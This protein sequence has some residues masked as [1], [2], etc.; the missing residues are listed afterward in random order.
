MEKFYCIAGAPGLVAL[1]LAVLG[2]DNGDDLAPAE[3]AD[4][5]LFALLNTTNSMASSLLST[6][7]V[8]YG[9]ERGCLQLIALLSGWSHSVNT[10]EKMDRHERTQTFLARRSSWLDLPIPPKSGGT[11]H[12]STDS[13][14][15][16]TSLP[17]RNSILAEQ[18]PTPTCVC[19]VWCV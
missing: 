8:P 11:M 1:V 14:H 17:A 10:K 16:N 13:T 6:V 9:R 2:D 5:G 12:S 18:A 19:G 4:Q 7:Y 3:T 15:P